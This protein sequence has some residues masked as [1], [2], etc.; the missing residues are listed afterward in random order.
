[1]DDWGSWESLYMT[2]QGQFALT[3]GDGNPQGPL[4][5]CANVLD[6]A[7]GPNGFVC[8]NADWNDPTGSNLCGLCKQ[9]IN[10]WMM[11]EAYHACPNDVAKPPNE[12]VCW[13]THQG[14][15]FATETEPMCTPTQGDG[16]GNKEALI[17]YTPNF[18][19][20]ARLG[21]HLAPP[22]AYE[23]GPAP[24][25]PEGNE[26]FCV[27]GGQIGGGVTWAP[28][29]GSCYLEWQWPVPDASAL[30]ADYYPNG[31]A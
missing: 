16:A 10:R 7:T 3:D 15:I 14:H 18:Q 20:C 1:M 25:Q 11:I 5:V 6:Y 9:E 27:N 17:G 22:W 4:Y 26:N 19:S 2:V 13:G 23:C 31:Q 12:G 8:A 21:A 30:P 24:A 28:E 29:D